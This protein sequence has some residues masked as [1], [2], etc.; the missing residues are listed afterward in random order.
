MR[1]WARRRWSPGATDPTSIL[2][3]FGGL[4]GLVYFLYGFTRKLF[5]EVP[6]LKLACTTLLLEQ[7]EALE[8]TAQSS[9]A[10]PGHGEGLAD[11]LDVGGF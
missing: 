7:H 1:A 5:L 8:R 11:A 9:A 6:L 2:I 3:V 10:L 4:T